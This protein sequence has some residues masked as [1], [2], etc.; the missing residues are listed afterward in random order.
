MSSF[1]SGSSA[2]G[3]IT[4]LMLSQV[5]R[6]VAGSFA[7]AFQ[8]LLIQSVRRVAMMSSYTARISGLASSYSISR[9]II[10]LVFP[11]NADAAQLFAQPTRR[12]QAEH[13]KITDQRPARMPES[14]RPIAFEDEVA[15]PRQSI[16]DD[17]GSDQPAPIALR[18]GGAERRER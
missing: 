8:K 14:L 5:R 1:V 13:T 9:T 11:R 16:A 18:R 2:P 6:S 3:A 10:A 15:E 17:R 4:C 7:S 12:E